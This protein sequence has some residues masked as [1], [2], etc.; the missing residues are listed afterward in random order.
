M[1]AS[2]AALLRG[3]C[4]SEVTFSAPRPAEI[5]LVRQATLVL[6]S[7]SHIQSWRI[8]ALLLSCASTTFHG[9]LISLARMDA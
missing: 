7:I 1:T 2:D 8:K 3:T 4:V 5:D 9:D 6:L